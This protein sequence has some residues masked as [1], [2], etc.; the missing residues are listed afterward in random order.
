MDRSGS[1]NDDDLNSLMDH[2][3]QEIDDLLSTKGRLSVFHP[4]PASSEGDMAK[5][6]DHRS[7]PA[8]GRDRPDTS[9]SPVAADK[10]AT[11]AAGGGSERE[12]PKGDVGHSAPDPKQKP[13][14][15]SARGTGA[16]AASVL[17]MSA[18]APTGS[19]E[20]VGSFSSCTGPRRTRLELG[21]PS[22]ATVVNRD[23]T[24]GHRNGQ[25]RDPC[26]GQ[27]VTTQFPKREGVRS[28]VYGAGA[29]HDGGGGIIADHLCSP[30]RR[31]SER[32][33]KATPFIKVKGLTL[34]HAQAKLFGLVGSSAAAPPVV[35]GG[36]AKE[37]DLKSTVTW[38]GS[39]SKSQT[40]G[41][42]SKS[43][44]LGGGSAAQE[45]STHG[46]QQP[47]PRRITY[48][49]S[50][51]EQLSNP[52]PGRGRSGEHQRAGDGGKN[53]AGGGD[54]APFT[55]KRSRKAEAAMR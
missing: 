6:G 28:Y 36:V 7:S 40:T 8:A 32:E 53:G 38:P 27:E 54:E 2:G 15:T 10:D 46:R 29:L 33:R 22:S 39:G 4:P 48:S 16:N 20:A 18:T 11:V 13:Q 26:G 47:N 55:W 23:G 9:S 17:M 14:H 43:T 51:M 1:N 41:G 25:A 19:A 31:R 44:G 52:V 50:R 42:T 30:P 12:Q 5:T 35:H 21:E 34:T 45:G 49:P 24:G 3:L 37:S